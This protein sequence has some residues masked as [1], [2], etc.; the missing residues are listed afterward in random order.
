MNTFFGFEGRSIL[1]EFLIDGEIVLTD[2]QDS[3]CLGSFDNPDADTTG[4]RLLVEF[5]FVNGMNGLKAEQG[6]FWTLKVF[7]SKGPTTID[8]V[9]GCPEDVMAKYHLDQMEKY[10][11]LYQSDFD[12]AMGRFSVLL[13]ENPKPILKVVSEP[14]T[15]GNT[16]DDT[17]LVFVA[18]VIEEYEKN[19]KNPSKL[20]EDVLKLG[21]EERI[22][23]QQAIKKSKSSKI[24]IPNPNNPD[25]PDWEIDSE[26]IEHYG[27]PE[28]DDQTALQGLLEDL[29]D[30]GVSK[31][32]LLSS[33]LSYV[34]W[35]SDDFPGT[36]REVHIGTDEWELCFEWDE[37]DEW[38][39]DEW[40]NDDSEDW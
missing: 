20:L 24:E 11:E 23:I 13:G 25:E 21:E 17:D 7:N 14:N 16:D 34:V 12:G 9:R 40:G 37:D 29:L 3:I 36:S 27:F 26:R 22:R 31:E 6:N 8:I 18:K 5:Y 32:S 2:D 10:P 35:G 1:K 19:R 15:N 4:H 33:D 38:G 39:D 28:D 30:A